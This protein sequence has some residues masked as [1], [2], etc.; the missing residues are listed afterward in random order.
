MS[1]VL[2]TIDGVRTPDFYVFKAPWLIITGSG[3]DDWMIGFISSFFYK[4]S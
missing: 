4:Q 3:L 1:R 2:V